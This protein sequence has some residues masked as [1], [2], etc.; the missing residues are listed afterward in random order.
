[1]TKSDKVVEEILKTTIQDKHFAFYTGPGSQIFR[2]CI[3]AKMEYSDL[4]YSKELY[5]FH[6]DL[7]DKL[8]FA[9]NPKVNYCPECEHCNPEEEE[10][11]E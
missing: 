8:I 1:M 6:Y 4:P 11:H 9:K 3:E 2:L 7:Y 10:I 5:E